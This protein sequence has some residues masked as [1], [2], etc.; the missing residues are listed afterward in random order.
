MSEHQPSLPPPRVSPKSIRSPWNLS[1]ERARQESDPEMLLPL[2]HATEAELYFRWEE[3]GDD[4]AHGQERAAMETAAKDLLA[5]KIHKLG[6]PD[7]CS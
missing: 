3:M 2:I 5:I 7:P 1:L 6:W 4:T